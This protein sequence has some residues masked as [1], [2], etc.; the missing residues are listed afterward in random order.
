VFGL[1][2]RDDHPMIA[3]LQEVL[4]R[5][6]CPRTRAI[7]ARIPG[8]TAAAFSWVGPGTHVFAHADGSA[9]PS[10]RFHFALRVDPSALLRVDQETRGW[11]PG[12]CVCFETSRVHEVL[13]EGVE[14]RVVLLGEIELAR[15]HERVLPPAGPE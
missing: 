4:R 15:I 3:H 1:F 12:R 9:Q 2:S 8:L 14:P 6:R 13:H 11:E 5:D 7:L 10:L